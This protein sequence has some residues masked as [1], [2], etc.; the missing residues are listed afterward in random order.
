MLS[1]TQT[2][3]T[4]KCRTCRIRQRSGDCSRDATAEFCFLVESAELWLTGFTVHVV[5]LLKYSNE[6]LADSVEDV[7]EVLMK[8]TGKLKYEA[9]RKSVMDI[10]LL[11]DK[12]ASSTSELS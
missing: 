7:Q 2:S 10:E 6:T 1:P 12:E 8:V 3:D 9:Q 11:E 5:K 4:V